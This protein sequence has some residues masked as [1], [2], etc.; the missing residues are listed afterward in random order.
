MQP[1]FRSPYRSTNKS[2]LKPLT[3]GTMHSQSAPFCVP[4]E[5]I[6]ASL[7]L[8]FRDSE[9]NFEVGLCHTR[10]RKKMKGKAEPDV[11]GCHAPQIQST[12]D[13]E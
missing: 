5:I 6:S 8:V 12:P 1:S 9:M 13:W 11:S 7:S 3:F 10:T 4:I 2:T